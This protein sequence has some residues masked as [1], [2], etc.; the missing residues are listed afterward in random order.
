MGEF[1][2]DVFVG[3]FGENLKARVDRDPSKIIAFYLPQFH[4]IRENSE[5]WSPGFTEWTN[6]A[7]AT[8]NFEGHYQPHVPRELGFYDLA[9][10]NIMEEQVALARAYGVHGFSFYYYWFS[11]RRILEKPID[12]FIASE[13]DFPF[14][15]TWAN[16]NWTRTWDG[17]DKLILLDQKYEPGFE[18]KLIEDMAPAFADKRYI[19]VND[20]PMLIIYR[21][22]AIP[23]V[24]QVI[25]N[26]KREAKKLGFKDLHIVVTDFYDLNSPNEVGAD[27]LVEFPPHKFN[28]PNNLYEHPVS[29]LNQSFRGGLVDYR[30]V[31]I[32]S[33]KRSKPSF[34]LYR[35]AMPSWDNTARRQDT[36]TVFV[37][38]NPSLF[39]VWLEN[40]RAYN[41]ESNLEGKDDSFI[42]IN[43]WNEW[44]E[45]AHLEPDLK[46]G[47]G[48]LEA[49]LSSSWFDPSSARQSQREQIDQINAAAASELSPLGHAGP[50]PIQ[51]SDFNKLP[52][53]NVLHRVS[54]WL[55]KFPK[56]FEFLRHLYLAF[57]AII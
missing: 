2:N 21:A 34:K 37:G 3:V 5:W 43:A 22:K 20:S 17:K 11:G 46:F 36:P 44:A 7:T 47:L 31:V 45:G 1:R 56:L 41:R 42:F 51:E 16:E 8:K 38:A 24:E 27:A 28:G 9:S 26:M 39:R 23:N 14:C 32:Q 13:I 35:T 30:K 12:N 53:M 40:L 52:R 48:N 55:T 18:H 57:K 4:R 15:F 25:K 49:V 33:L 50:K 19:R 29:F 10:A 54:H 6:V